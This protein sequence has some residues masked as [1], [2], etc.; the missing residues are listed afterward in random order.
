MSCLL[1]LVV[2]VSFWIIR[3]PSFNYLIFMVE[4]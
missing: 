1:A 2:G 4:F 3:I